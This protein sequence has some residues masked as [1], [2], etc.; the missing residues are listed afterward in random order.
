MSWLTDIG[1][2]LSGVASSVSTNA[3]AFGSNVYAAGSYVAGGA[4]NVVS[5]AVNHPLE[6]LQVGAGAVLVA[7]GVGVP[8]GAT[9]ITKGGLALAAAAFDEAAKDDASHVTSAA[10]PVMAARVAIRLRDDSDFRETR[11]IL[12]AASAA[13]EAQV[14]QATADRADNP[15]VCDELRSAWKELVRS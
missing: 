1:N 9:L 11:P 10:A 8:L 4:E 15:T 6:S 2:T 13:K 3:Q 14:K 12:D 7:T 5:A